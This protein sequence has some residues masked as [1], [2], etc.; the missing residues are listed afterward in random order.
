MK[1]ILRKEHD[2]LGQIGTIADVKDG[3]ARN[4]LI[5][6]GIAYPATDGSMR[7]LEEEK[8]Q[9][10][11]RSNKEMKESEKLAANLDKVSLTIKMK[12]GEDE[13]LFGSVTA[14]MVADALKEQGYTID[15][16]VIDLEE[17]IKALGIYTVNVKLHASVVGKV[18]VWVV[19]E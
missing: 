11:R 1:V 5:P 8:K 19:S 7:A 18:K 10:E 12:V 3:Y 13:K 16:R 17:P 4:Y 9:A 14:Q 6:R 15:K 2:K